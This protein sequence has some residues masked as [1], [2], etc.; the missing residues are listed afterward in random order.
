MFTII[1]RQLVEDETIDLQY[2]PT[3]DQTVDILAKPL[4]PDKFV[5]FRGKLGVVDRLTIKGGYYDNRE[6][7]LLFNGYL[8]YN[9]S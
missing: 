9:L 8:F 3:M 6:L 4:G 7:L 1:T 2:V 5:K